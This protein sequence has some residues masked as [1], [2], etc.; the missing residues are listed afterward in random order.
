MNRAA[1]IVSENCEHKQH[2]EGDGG[3]DEEIHGN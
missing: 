3:H 2:L 1:A